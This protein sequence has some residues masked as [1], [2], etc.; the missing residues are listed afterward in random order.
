[1]DTTSKNEGCCRPCVADTSGIARMPYSNKVDFNIKTTFF[2]NIHEMDSFIG[3]NKINLFCSKLGTENDTPSCQNMSARSGVS[4][5]AKPTGSVPEIVSQ[6]DEVDYILSHSKSNRFMH[7]YRSR[8]GATSCRINQNLFD[9]TM[10]T[11][12]QKHM[13]NEKRS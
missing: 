3:S 4:K 9:N 13:S 8:H 6:S 10:E 11:H 7:T 2:L 5:I 1:M 12:C